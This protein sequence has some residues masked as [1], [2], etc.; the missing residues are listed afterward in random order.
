MQ[1]GWYR[2][3]HGAHLSVRFPSAPGVYDVTDRDF[4]F[5]PAVHRGSYSG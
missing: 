3:L 5:G 4:D 2:T 1:V